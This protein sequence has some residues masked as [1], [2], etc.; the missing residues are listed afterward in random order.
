MDNV[1]N[2]ELYLSQLIEDLKL[3]TVYLPDSKKNATVSNADINRPALQIAGYF[4]HFDNTRVQI[5]GMVENDY[6]Y[7][8]DAQTRRFNLDKFFSFRFPCLIITRDLFVPNEVVEMA[9][10]YEVPI[11]RTPKHTSAFTARIIYYM[12]TK[13]GPQITRHGVLVEVYGEGILILGESGVGKSETTI[14]LIK[15]GH[16]LIADDAVIIK[17]VNSTDLVGTAPEVIRDFIELRGIGIVNVRRLFGVGAV[18]ERA[19]IDMV[20]NIENWDTSKTYDRLGMDTE[21][22]DIL[23]V[24]LPSLT[25]PVKPGRNLAVILE[26]AAMNNRQRRMGY[27]AAE[28]LNKKIMNDM[29]QRLAKEQE[30]E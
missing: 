7:D 27:N 30:N 12:N 25:I 23:G 15:R 11:L 21:F 29:E 3:E 8:I 20:V 22:M 1:E 16:Q 19:Y 24:K 9:Q 28:E 10:K 17:K 4:N 6:L 26:V 14:E 5:F 18:K 2:C 13:L